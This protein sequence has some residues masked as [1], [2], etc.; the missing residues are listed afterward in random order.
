MTK[1][2]AAKPVFCGQWTCKRCA[3]L[4]ARKWAKRVKMH[5]ELEK[6]EI[7][8]GEIKLFMFI[9]LTLPGKVRT[10]ERG[11]EL[12]PKL[13]DRLRTIMKRKLGK[14][15]QYV[16][17]VEG[18]PERSHMPHFHIISNRPLLHSPFCVCYSS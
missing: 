1:E 14:G 15:W 7:Q 9:T 11:F 6:A 8:H 10:P 3:K 2:G 13:W 16:A 12:L 5:I 17:F 18:Q 4:L